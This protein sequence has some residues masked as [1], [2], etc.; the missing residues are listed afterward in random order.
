MPF[1]ST[2]ISIIGCGH[3]GTTCAYALLQ[4]R[5]CREIV[6]IDEAQD[7]VHGE[8]LDLQQ[9]V[10][11]GMPVKIFAGGYKDAAASSIVVLTVGAPVKFTGSRLDLLAANIDVLRACV[12]RLMAEHFD[13][14]LLLATNPVDIL[15]FVAQR[16]SGLPVSQVIGSGTLIDTERFRFILGESLNVDARSVDAAMIGEHGD[17]SVAVWSSA[18][19]GGVPLAAYPGAK[20][21]PSRE[22]LLARV[23]RAGPEVFALK[24]N[25]CFAIA[26]CV[27]RICEAIL[28]DERS[29]LVVSTLMTGQYGLHDVSLSTPCVIGKSGVESVLELRLEEL[30]QRALDHSAE[31]LQDAYAG[32]HAS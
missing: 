15:T 4:S 30:E 22:E 32:L 27:T 19:V 10:P 29:V 13:G 3:V 28:R 26:S 16:E 11:L 24:G 14:V 12:G 20:G 21:L 7:L 2:R 5:L 18:Q 31:T 9:S 17:T 25:T 8:A 1:H 23:R 6:L